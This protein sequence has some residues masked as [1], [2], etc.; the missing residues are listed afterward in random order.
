MTTLTVDVVNVH[1][2]LAYLPLSD[3]LTAS[4]DLTVTEA[5]RSIA[6][7]HMIIGPLAVLVS[8]RTR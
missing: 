2:A 8:E 5:L 6:A 4:L 1:A 7:S 3:P